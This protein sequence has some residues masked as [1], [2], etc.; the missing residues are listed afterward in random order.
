[1]APCGV[2]SVLQNVGKGKGKNLCFA[3]QLK[4]GSEFVNTYKKGKHIKIVVYACIW[5]VTSAWH[6]SDL[7]VMQRD[8]DAKTKAHTRFS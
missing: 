1:M 7:V 4:L 5:I 6:K 3:L 8:E 2:V